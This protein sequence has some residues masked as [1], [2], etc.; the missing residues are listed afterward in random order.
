M[1]LIQQNG[2]KEVAIRLEIT[3]QEDLNKIEK[4]LLN[5]MLEMMSS[6]LTWKDDNLIA[7]CGNMLS[8][9][10]DN[11]NQAMQMQH[12][13]Q[14]PKEHKAAESS[15]VSDLQQMIDDLPSQP[16]PKP[17]AKKKSKKKPPKKEGK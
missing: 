7:L 9:V 16:Q 3:R 14:L 12:M 2:R 5:L 13:M 8:Q 10:S 4:A 1:S 15:T 17:K 11:L 6:L